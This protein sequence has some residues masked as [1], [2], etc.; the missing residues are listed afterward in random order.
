MCVCVFHPSITFSCVQ[1]LGGAGSP[2]QL[3]RGGGW[4]Y[5]PRQ[6]GSTSPGTHGDTK[7]NHHPFTH[8]YTLTLADGRAEEEMRRSHADTGRKQN[9]QTSFSEYDVRRGTAAMK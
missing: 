3:S 2:S 4:G 1:D 8:T 7:K 6:V 5:T 9:P